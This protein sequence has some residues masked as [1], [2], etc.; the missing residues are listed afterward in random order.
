MKIALQI[1]LIPG[2]SAA[3]KISW[4]ADHGVDGIEITA[5]NYKLDQIT[6]A[7]KDF[8]NSKV[9]VVSICG[10]PSFDFLDPDPKKRRVS[11]DESKKYLEL[12]GHFRAVGQI[13]PPI[14]GGPR[15]N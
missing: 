14:F 2:E 15:I 9:P 5:W 6:Q 12:A 7:K 8:E 1:G 4:A 3:D 11:I 13:V 10:N